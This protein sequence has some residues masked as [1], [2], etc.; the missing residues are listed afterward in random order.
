MVEV[1]KQIYGKVYVIRTL[2]SAVQ[3]NTGRSY[4]IMDGYN[5][6]RVGE[7][8]DN[9]TAAIGMISEREEEQRRVGLRLAYNKAN[10][11]NNIRDWI[12]SE[13]TELKIDKFKY[14]GEYR[15]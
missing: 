13:G 12:T 2:V 6:I 8:K 11:L 14:L 4:Q 1:S 9:R 3:H 5:K 7:N 15:T 10:T